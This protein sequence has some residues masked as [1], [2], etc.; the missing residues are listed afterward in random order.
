MS[1][2]H[3]VPATDVSAFY[4]AATST[5]TVVAQVT[6]G[7]GNFGIEICRSLI[8]P[9]DAPIPAFVIAAPAPTGVQPDFI[10]TRTISESFLMKKAPATIAVYS[11]G[12]DGPAKT[13]VRVGDLPATTPTAKSNTAAAP[14]PAAGAPVGSQDA[15]GWSPAFDYHAALADAIMKLKAAV[16]FTNPDIG[17]RATVVATGV[18]VG[19]FTVNRGLYVTLRT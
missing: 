19:G 13:E 18:Q 5:L 7:P 10:T 1:C 8:D 6:F 9:F 4:T 2:H 14:A 15:T 11:A 3:L 17:L 12:V 16:G